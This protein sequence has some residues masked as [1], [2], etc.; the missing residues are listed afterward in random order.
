MDILRR[1]PGA[2]SAK[3]G[4]SGVSEKTEIF[5]ES[6]MIGNGRT[7]MRP[8]VFRAAAQISSYASAQPLE[9]YVR[10]A[11]CLRLLPHSCNS[12]ERRIRLYP[13]FASEV[14]SQN[15]P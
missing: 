8:P 9:G 3:S 7:L 2:Q 11:F 6:G 15:M 14:L 5:R 12:P 4:G 10:P 1:A 13:E